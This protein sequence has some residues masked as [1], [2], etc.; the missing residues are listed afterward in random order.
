MEIS[1]V[2]VFILGAFWSAK[3][4]ALGSL[5]TLPYDPGGAWDNP[6]TLGLFGRLEGI[7][8]RTIHGDTQSIAILLPAYG[9]NSLLYSSVASDRWEYGV[10]LSKIA[11]PWLSVGGLVAYAHLGKEH[12]VPLSFGVVPQ[13]SIRSLGRLAGGI[14]F[15]D[16]LGE[17]GTNLSFS[18]VTGYSVPYLIIADFR[19]AWGEN[20]WRMSVGTD[21]SFT[22]SSFADFSIRAGW[23]EDPIADRRGPTWGFGLGL[24]FAS[25]DFGA[26]GLDYFLGSV[27]LFW[28]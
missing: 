3:G 24:P 21:A 19:Q 10:S 28:K 11:F 7:Y 16:L 18:L 23:R 1:G 20:R 26:E 8:A 17:P 13:W 27:D 12:N 6:G 9:F 15:Y 25:L 22:V 5:S 2:I 4:I 14:G